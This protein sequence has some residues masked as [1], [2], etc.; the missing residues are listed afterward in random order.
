MVVIITKPLLLSGGFVYEKLYIHSENNKYIYQYKDHLGNA[1]VSFAKDKT[2]VLE[3]TDIN[4][5]YAFGMNHIGGVKGLLGG[6]MN[7]KYNS[8]ELQE[9]GIYDYGARF[10]MADIGRWGV[11]DPLAETDRRWTPYR[12]AYDNPI[13]FIDPDGRNE[14]IYEMDENANLTW[15][16]SSDRDVVYASK[17]FDNNGK[18]KADNDGGVD[19]GEKGY[20]EKNRQ[21]ITLKTPVKDSEGNISNRMSTLSFYNN[22]A[23]AKELVEYMYNNT[24]VESSN[25]S[26]IGSKGVFSIIGT[27]HLPTGS[28]FNAKDLG[29]PNFSFNNDY[30]FPSKL[31][32]QDHNHP[33]DGLG[34]NPASGFEKYSKGFR[35]SY[36]VRCATGGCDINVAKDNP[37][38]K[39]RVYINQLKKYMNYDSQKTDFE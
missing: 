21:E 18:L 37:T 11:V 36:D 32:A 24:N 16:A 25:A 2:S 7:Y 6:Y 34:W 23:R 30:F 29:M 1:R 5:Y 19:I 31:F 3:I 38:I 35:P 4:N 39:L 20:I 27:F 13:R 12:Y 33:N 10:Y 17:N 14:D 9:T 8:K 26:F 28:P 22:E 15:K